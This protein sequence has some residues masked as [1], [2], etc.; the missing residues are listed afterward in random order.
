M[1]KYKYIHNFPKPFLQDLV[2]S[3]SLP[4]VGAGFSKNA[5]IPRRKKML[6]WDELG[7]AVAEEIQD[8][9]Y[10]NAIDAISAYC[11]EY[12]RTSLIEKLTKLLLINS[13][14][15]GKSHK[16]F[17]DLQF[18]IV[19]T[20]NFDFLLEQGYQLSSKYCRPILDEDQLSINTGND[21]PILLKIH[22]DLHHPNRLVATEEDYDRFISSNPMLSTYLANLLITRTPL[23]IG[24][25]LDDA[26]FRQ[27]WQLI[28]DRLGNLRR[29]AY[30]IKVNCSSHEKARFERRGVKV[31]NIT[32]QSS[33]YPQILEDVF[34]ELKDYWNQEILKYPT[35]SEEDTLAE[36]ALPNDTNNRLCFFS[37]PLKLTP[38]Y[39]KYIFPIVSQCGLVPISADDVIS[40]GDNWI[41]KVSALI[42]KAEFVI[43]DLSTQNTQ[44]ELNLILNQNKHKDKLLVIYPEDSPLLM[45]ISNLRSVTRYENPFDSVDDLSGFLIDWLKFT[46]DPLKEVYDEE[47]RR[48]LKAREYRAAVISAMT[49]L[50]VNIRSKVELIKQINL[51]FTTPSR[52]YSIA[53]DFGIIEYQDLGNIKSWL[54]IRN[55]LVHNRIN[56]QSTEAKSIVNAVYQILNRLIKDE[57]SNLLI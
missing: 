3:K 26:D 8:Y 43:V 49:L 45:D 57:D 11:H 18:D 44:Y 51:K 47:P 22:G 36:L 7:K 40:P 31:I 15:P 39:K 29:Q 48:L 10:T 41:A 27:I 5:E 54:N 37:V 25:S 53:A 13:I 30:V 23:F 35:V 1:K 46:L 21:G 28:K 6:D 14:K 20:T 16:A 24:Y 55:H 12:S 19:C 42:T 9:R 32:G 2:E 52:L 50:E 38:F 4:F 56:I 34:I 33:D 17:C